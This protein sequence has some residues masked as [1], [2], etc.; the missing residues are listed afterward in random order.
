MRVRR[1]H[2]VL[3]IAL[4]STTSM[5]LAADRPPRDLHFVDG[6]WTA[7]NP[8]APPEGE[9]VHV[10]ARGDTLWDLAA[11]LRDQ[12]LARSAGGPCAGG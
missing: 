2:C 1:S 6:H 8:P 9:Q 3:A 11:K 12:P 7:W 10:I 4:F 5:A